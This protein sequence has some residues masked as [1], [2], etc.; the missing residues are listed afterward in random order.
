M[1]S[2]SHRRSV[3][4]SIELSFFAK[5]NFNRYQEKYY[6]I[7]ENI[8]QNSPPLSSS[9]SHRDSGPDAELEL[10]GPR[11]GIPDKSPPKG[12]MRCIPNSKLPWPTAGKQPQT[13]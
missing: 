3:V 12:R 8:R 9:K 11:I 13:T 1:E 5:N 7:V 6:H 2:R 10:G 4:L